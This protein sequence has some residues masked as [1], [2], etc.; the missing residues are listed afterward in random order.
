MT[1]KEF[2]LTIT[3]ICVAVFLM[4]SLSEKKKIE[5]RF[6]TLQRVNIEYV[7]TSSQ[8]IHDQELVIQ[9]LQQQINQE[10]RKK[11]KLLAL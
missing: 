11:A 9:I 10:A 3:L 4:M 1:F 8:V 2:L 7:S 5:E 6:A